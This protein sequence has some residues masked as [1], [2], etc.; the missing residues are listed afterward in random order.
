MSDSLE[1]EHYRIQYP[2]AARPR[3]LIEDRSFDVI[4]LSERGIRFRVEEGVTFPVGREV[5][6]AIRFRRNEP[7]EVMGSVVRVAAL[8]V[9]VKLDV[10]VPLRTI[11]EEQRFLREHHRGTAW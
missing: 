10:G 2:P 8:E 1:R 11:I 7:V 4:D 9:A 3:I 6:G 5:S